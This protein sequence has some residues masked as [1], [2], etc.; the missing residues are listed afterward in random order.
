MAGTIIYIG[1]FCNQNC[2]FCLGSKK[3]RKFGNI[4]D[5]DKVSGRLIISGGEPILANDFFEVISIC[6]RNNNIQEI[7]LQSNGVILSYENIVDKILEYNFITE[8]NIN[9]PSYKKEIDRI[10]TQANYFDY[11]IRGITNLIKRMLNV[12]LTFVINRLNF[13]QMKEYLRFVYITFNNKPQVQF[14]FVQIQG[15][16]KQ[17]IRIIPRYSEI[18]S[19]LISAIQFA[20]EFNV[21][22]LIDNIPLCIFYPFIEH[23]VDYLKIKIGDKSFHKKTKL[24]CCN[25]CKLSKACFGPPLD[26]ISLYGEQ[27]FKAII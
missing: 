27:E 20:E 24:A 2:L 8:Y 9:F 14:S 11:R 15:R 3:Q 17:F 26:Y 12:R 13:R 1:S 4:I 18:K 7:E 25:S 10:I 21:R 22:C 5:I 16:A 23:S 19:E 6:K